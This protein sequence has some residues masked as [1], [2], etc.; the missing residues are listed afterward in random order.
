MG[1][2]RDIVV[3]I[4]ACP[5]TRREVLGYVYG[6]ARPHRAGRVRCVQEWLSAMHSAG[7]IYV[8]AWHRHAGWV[9]PIYAVQTESLFC[10]DDADAPAGLKIGVQ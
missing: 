6:D 10:Q 1:R 4:L 5:S 7:V 3:E 8:H 2:S 9:V